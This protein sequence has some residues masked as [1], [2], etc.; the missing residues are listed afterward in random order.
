MTYV[1]KEF[2]E[3]YKNFLDINDLVLNEEKIATYMKAVPLLERMFSVDVVASEPG[4]EEFLSLAILP[5]FD[6]CGLE[7]CFFLDVF[8]WYNDNLPHSPDIKDFADLVRLF[9][10]LELVRYDDSRIEVRLTLDNVWREA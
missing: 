9:S 4:F 7:V 8:T 6:T 3:I 2:L 1:E 5:A 10:R